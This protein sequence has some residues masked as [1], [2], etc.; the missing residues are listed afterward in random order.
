M[1]RIVRRREAGLFVGRDLLV[2]RPRVR[3]ARALAERW[4]TVRFT[5]LRQERV[6]HV[7]ENDL[8]VHEIGAVGSIVRLRRRENLRAGRIRVVRRRG[9][10]ARVEA[11]GRL[12]L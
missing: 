3:L 4:Y 10:H 8:S 11:G 12:L 6:L 7:G 5:D 9:R 2:R 1:V